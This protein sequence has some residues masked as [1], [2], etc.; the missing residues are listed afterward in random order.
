MSERSKK[1]MLLACNRR[2]SAAS[3][4]ASISSWERGAATS[5]PAVVAQRVVAD[6][7]SI[8]MRCRRRCQQD[9]GNYFSFPAAALLHANSEDSKA[10]NMLLLRIVR[11]IYSS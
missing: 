10:A 11:S 1:S 6:F 5:T 8:L 7:K 3:R 4:M 9:N 2:K